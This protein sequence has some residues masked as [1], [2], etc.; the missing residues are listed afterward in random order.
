MRRA[1]RRNNTT[2]GM[3][4]VQE[5]NLRSRQW[6]GTVWEDE[7]INYVKNLSYKY[8]LI[9]DLDHTE[10][11][12]EHRHVFIQFRDARSRPNTHNAHWEKVIDIS[13]AI[14]YCMDKG[15]E[16]YEDGD[17]G[18]NTRNEHDWKY[19]VNECKTKNPRELIDGPCSRLYAQY[20][21]FAGEVSNQFRKLDIIDG[22]LKNEW[23]WGEPG[24]G[25]TRDAWE[26]YPDLYIK[27]IN[28]WWDGYNNE[29][30]VLLDDWDPNHKVLVNHL[31]VWSDRY[32]FRA[33][34][35][36]SSM[37][38]R[39]KKIIITSNYPPERC[40]DNDEDIKAIRRR[41]KVTQF[42]ESLN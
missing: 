23:N 29:E 2:T 1:Q 18:I 32:P 34:T 35:K 28:K 13:G 15:P 4:R 12:Q 42:H 25:K 17:L 8:I 26:R 20:R 9:S 31:K 5:E 37:T 11:G 6:M 24:T 16:Y 38:I 19:F 21:S 36:G 41:F 22:Q 14:K 3:R 33:E 27:N 40:F 30:V 10:E 39:P 7:D